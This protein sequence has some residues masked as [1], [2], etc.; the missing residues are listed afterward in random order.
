MLGTPA[1]EHTYSASIIYFNGRETAVDVISGSFSLSV[2][3][4]VLKPT[5]QDQ[6]N[7]FIFSRRYS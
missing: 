2:E 5:G 1:T 6:S 3:S 4:V 7:L